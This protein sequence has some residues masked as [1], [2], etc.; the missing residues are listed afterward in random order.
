MSYNE[1]VQRYNVPD[2]ALADVVIEC[3]KNGARIPWSYWKDKP[4]RREDYLAAPFIDDPM[5]MFDCD[6]PVDGVAAFVLAS[7]ERAKDMPNKPVYISGYA[8]ALPLRRRMTSHWPYDDLM[9]LGAESVKQLVQRA[10]ISAKDIDYPQ[11]YDGFA[12]LV[13]FW[14]ELLGLCPRGEA[15]R[16]VAGGGIDSDNPSAVPALAGGGALG[17]GRMH[18]TPQMIECYLQLAE[19]A[20]ARQ[21]KKKPSIAI[22]C[23]GI[24]HVGGAVV[25]SATPY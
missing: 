5:R 12:P 19:R 3:R 16:F 14:L 24:P 7:A 18:G 23:Q 1:Y 17:N 13:Y 10:G 2:N 11:V 9:D 6:I 15:H 20:G 21:R 25:Y 8:E 22:A 4:L